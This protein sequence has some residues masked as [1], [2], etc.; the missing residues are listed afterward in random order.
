MRVLLVDDSDAIRFTMSALL[1]DAGHAVI[2]AE[3]LEA[4]RAILAAE[5]ASSFEVGVIDLHLE[6]GDGSELI[7]ELRAADQAITLVLLTGEPSPDKLGADIVLTKG[8]RPNAIVS[9]I[10][11]AVAARRAAAR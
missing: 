4:A 5:P 8:D 3:S 11:A 7:S 1:E 6:D 2:E 9:S 10:E